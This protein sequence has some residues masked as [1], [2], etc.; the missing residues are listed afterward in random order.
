M[1][2]PLGCPLCGYAAEHPQSNLDDHITKH[3]H[4]FALRCL[5]WGTCGNETVSVNAK[6]TSASNLTG[7]TDE[8]GEDGEPAYLD[9]TEADTPTQL[10]KIL[11]LLGKPKVPTW[12]YDKQLQE[13]LLS[14]EERLFEHLLVAEPLVKRQADQLTQQ[15]SH[16]LALA[17]MF[18]PTGFMTPD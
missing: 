7:L 2:E 15:R 4:G 11:S 1:L 18:A 13:L 5:P 12:P 9:V 16:P 17:D 8:D 14:V 3:L 10:H 6:S